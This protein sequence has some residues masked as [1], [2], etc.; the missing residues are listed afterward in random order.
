VLN[1]KHVQSGYGRVG[2][3]WDA[4]LDIGRGEIVSIIGPN[5]AGKTTLLKTISGVVQCKAGTISFQ[6]QEIQQRPPHE[7][8][9]LGIIQ[10]PEGR[11]IID[12]FTVRENLLMGCYRRYGELGP[13]GRDELLHYVTELF[14][15]LGNRMNQIAGTLSGGE[16]QM[17]AISRA[18][19]AQPKILLTD[20]PS[21][22][23]APIIV[24]QVC[25]ALLELNKQGLTILLIEQNALVALEMSERAYVLEGGKIILQGTGAELLHNDKVRQGYLGV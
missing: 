16:Q 10:V 9:D 20:E 24:E 7:I 2:V 3:V 23:L 11:Q 1:L 18:L 4:S 19:M 5:G 17:L 14:P 12:E 21:L 6:G 13:G 22:G 15:I 8:V 25:N